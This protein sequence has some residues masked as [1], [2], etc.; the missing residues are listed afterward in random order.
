MARTPL[1]CKDIANIVRAL[2]R[3]HELQQRPSEDMK[4]TMYSDKAKSI[5]GYYNAV[6][7]LHLDP[8]LQKHPELLK[9]HPATWDTTLGQGL[10]ALEKAAKRAEAS[11]RTPV[12]VQAE[13]G[14][15]TH[16]LESIL[17]DGQ[18]KI[19]CPK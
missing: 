18:F 10:R 1:D 2:L 7:H 5:V 15:V 9:A 17:T 16:A 14:M 12:Y 19:R 3:A 8:V 4:G 11:P 13:S 6:L